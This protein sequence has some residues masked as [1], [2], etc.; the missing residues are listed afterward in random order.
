MVTHS[1]GPSDPGP[2]RD[3]SGALRAAASAALDDGT[4][5]ALRHFLEVGPY[6]VDAQ[7]LSL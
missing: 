1:P 3:T 6:E 7:R 5:E 4:P 2:A